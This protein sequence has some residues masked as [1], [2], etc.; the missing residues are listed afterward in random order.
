[1]SVRI[2]PCNFTVDFEEMEGSPVENVSVEWAELGVSREFKC[3]AADRF[4]L[5]R[6]LIG[7][8]E[9]FGAN[10]VIHKPHAY[11]FISE[12]V[13]CTN[14]EV[15]PFGK[16][17]A[18]PDSRFSNY[19][20]VIVSAIYKIPQ[21]VMAEAFGALVTITETLQEASEFITL[22]E[23]GLYW[24]VS[25]G[26]F[27]GEELDY[28]DAPGKIS[29]LLEWTYEIRNALYVPAGVW[30]YPGHVN[31]YE[32][33]SRTFDIRFPA[34]TLLCGNPTVS[35]EISFSATTFN[36]SLRFLAKNNGTYAAPKGWNYFPRVSK[37]GGAISFEPIYD[38]NGVAKI[39]YPYADFRSIFVP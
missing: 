30:G 26:P 32:V 10:V 20:D 2:L 31:T 15:K 38:T 36:I 37:V 16:M 29:Q 7:F 27:V 25:T 28:M 5:V 17:I 22:P 11:T 18:G 21:G 8:T 4:S 9:V 24:L 34:G 23:K 13:M 39:I 6:S 35:K 3:A 33:Y 19:Q 12:L 1:M 14:V